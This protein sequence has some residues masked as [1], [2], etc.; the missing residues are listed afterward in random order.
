M[1]PLGIADRKWFYRLWEIIPGLTSWLFLLSPIVLS[2]VWPI[3]VAY[4]IIAYDLLWFL[5]S[6]RM[7]VGLLSAY[8]RL[9]MAKKIDWQPRL[10]QLED[11]E[12][13]LGKAQTQ[14][15][16]LP[17]PSFFDKLLMNK[18]AQAYEK[19]KQ[20]V[21]QLQQWVEHETALLKPSDIYHVVITAVYNES[22]DTLMPSVEAVLDSDFDSKK[23]IYVLAYEERGGEVTAENANI[24]EAK[25]AKRFK[26]YMS[27]C[28]PDGIEGE[29][30]GKG[31][32]I[33]Y[34]GRKVKEYLEQEGYDP[35]HVVVT[36]FDSDHRPDAKYFSY[37]T[38]EYCANP[39][40]THVSFQPMAMFFNNIWDAPAPM[41]V[42]A[43]GNSFWLLM[44]S[45]RYY[46]LRNFAAH[47]QSFK[48]LIDTDF[49]SVTTIV[50]DGHQYWRTFYTYD[51]DH[52]VE[53][54]YVPV[55]QDA[56]LADNY[57][58]TFKNQ[59]KQLR[60]WAYGASDVPFVV[61]NNLKNKQVPFF[62]KWLQFERLFEGH[63]A[64]ATAP[65][66]LTFAAW[67]PLLLNSDFTHQ[68]LAHQLPVVASRILTIALVGQFITICMSLLMLPP[69]PKRYRRT[70]FIFM[71]FQWVLVPLT[72]IGFGS[73]AALD[74]QTRLMIGRYPK[75]FDVTDKAVKKDK[76]KS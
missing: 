7:S 36:T 1:L 9:H 28:H 58:K 68:V 3:A 57:R 71:I 67:A 14:L 21:A 69:R 29:L 13:G 11:V 49:W 5:K 62:K 10:E 8:R 53:P 4:F 37:L 18:K 31:A 39:N 74:A 40:R 32:N 35:E 30:K 45:V 15:K 12:L 2:F 52:V 24:L 42:I 72:S 47:A 55:Y 23:I 43:T 59:Y 61:T 38:H 64:W 50:E 46:R 22:L 20:V 6:M 65:L 44:E 34:A 70:K 25:Y 41:R 76:I 17:S 54:L 60:R 56:V 33:T 51:G 19:Q 26:H 16:R 27:V 66:I 73:V 63:L 75:A 48:T